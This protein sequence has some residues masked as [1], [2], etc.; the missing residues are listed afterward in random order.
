VLELGRKVLVPHQLVF[1][2][3]VH[4]N[5]LVDV[6][7]QLLVLP[8]QPVLCVFVGAD[9]SLAPRLPVLGTLVLLGA[10]SDGRS[11]IFAVLESDFEILEEV[12]GL[13]DIV[14]NKKLG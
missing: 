3:V 4:A 11:V 7:L 14:H 13:V 12:E 8:L 6:L 9:Q 2:V 1:E 5:Q 10:H